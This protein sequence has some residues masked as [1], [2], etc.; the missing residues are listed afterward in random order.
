MAA[1]IWRVY[2]SSVRQCAT[3]SSL[4]TT[5]PRTMAAICMSVYQVRRRRPSPSNP[6]GI[7]RNRIVAGADGNLGEV[8]FSERLCHTEKA[9]G[10]RQ[11]KAGGASSL[12][13]IRCS[14][15]GP[16]AQWLEQGT[17]NPLVRG[18]NPCRPT[19]AS[20]FYCNG[21]QGLNHKDAKATAG[22]STSRRSGF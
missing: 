3:V 16:V 17:H 12:L 22:S 1:I 2:A 10:V 14:T 7:A 20:N 15:G 4:S 11:S 6:E 9:A 19:N 5:S 21:P 13:Q 8:T 18:S